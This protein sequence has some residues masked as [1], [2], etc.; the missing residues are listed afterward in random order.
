MS[1]RKSMSRPAAK[2]KFNRGKGV[3]PRNNAMSLRGGYRL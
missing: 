1:N 2:A 3:H